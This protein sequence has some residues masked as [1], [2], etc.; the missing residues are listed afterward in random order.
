MINRFPDL[1]GA[2]VNIP[3]NI[4]VF[5]NAGESVAIISNSTN[6][7]HSGSVRQIADNNG[8][9]VQPVGFSPQ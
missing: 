6:V 3:V 1:G 9:L 7:R 2:A 4:V 8:T 5:L